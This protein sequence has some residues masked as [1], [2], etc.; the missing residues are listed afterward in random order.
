VEPVPDQKKNA[1]ILNMFGDNGAK[2]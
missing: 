1:A 2:K